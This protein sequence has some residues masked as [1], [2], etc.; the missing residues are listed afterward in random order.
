MDGR[1][2]LFG[3]K[4]QMAAETL[5]RFANLV[6]PQIHESDSSDICYLVRPDGYI[7][8]ASQDMRVILKYLSDLAP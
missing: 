4:F 3:G 8:C 6:E 5:S 7:A 1:F 2:M